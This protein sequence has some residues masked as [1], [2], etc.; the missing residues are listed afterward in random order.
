MT[1][2]DERQY[3]NIIKG[4]GIVCIV[5]GHSYGTLG[6]FVYLFHLAI[7]F[8]VGGA[9]YKSKKYEDRP[10]LF[11]ANRIVANWKRYASYT[12]ALVLLHNL[13]VKTGMLINSGYYDLTQTVN[14]ILGTLLFDNLETLGGAL[15]FIPVYIFSSIIYG[16]IVSCGKHISKVYFHD[17]LNAK[18]LVIAVLGIIVGLLGLYANING[19][20]FRYNFH[21][22]LLVTPFFVGGYFLRGAIQ[23]RSKIFNPLGLI[24]SLLILLVLAYELNISI[25]LSCNKIGNAY[26]FYPVSFIGIYFCLCLGQLL[27]RIK[28][29]NGYFG[30]LGRHSMEIMACHLVVF[31]IF[32]CIAACILGISDPNVYGVFPCAFGQFW[33]MYILLGINVPVLLFLFLNR[34]K[35]KITSGKNAPPFPNCHGRRYDGEL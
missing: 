32:D 30:L 23:N 14:A 16:G 8:F 4:I 33:Y 26:I 35:T 17:S 11:F 5:I 6:R 20:V 28:Y 31:K 3:W 13:F 19:A 29:V 21:V 22:S 18:Y 7:F 27:L 10:K 24:V 15:W 9:L 2:S 34:L 1:D 25:D 12:I